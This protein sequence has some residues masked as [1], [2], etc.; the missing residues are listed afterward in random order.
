MPI[1]DL[2]IATP[3]LYFL[4]KGAVNG[5]VKEVLNIVGI[6]LAI[7]LTFNYLDAFTGI[8]APIF[9]EGASYVPFLSGV[10][11]FVGTLAVVALIAYGTKE[12]LK[13]VKLS[14]V[15][16][17]LGASFGALKSGMVV[18]AILLLLAGFNIPKDEARQDSYLY[19]YVIYLAPFAYNG[20]ALI[21]PGAENYTE[22]LKKNIGKYNPLENIPFLNE[23][24]E[25]KA[26]QDN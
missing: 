23:L 14:F 11:L 2:I 6:I 26:N 15:N 8:I 21:Y 7:F 22:T 13:A 16:R 3:I 20:V 24:Q 1:L 5:F 25:Q 17:I 18:S 4:Y 12:F 9:E 10:I 19:P